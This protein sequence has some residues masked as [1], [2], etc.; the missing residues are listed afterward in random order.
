MSSGSA[1]QARGFFW[2]TTP[3]PSSPDSAPDILPFI[4]IHHALSGDDVLGPVYYKKNHELK[5]NELRTSNIFA[6]HLKSMRCAVSDF[7][8][9]I[10]NEK[11][12]F[13]NKKLSSSL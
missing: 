11:I 1:L 5:K 3:R 10:K 7:T 12:Q 8:A 9:I 13:D 6:I 2:R 4:S